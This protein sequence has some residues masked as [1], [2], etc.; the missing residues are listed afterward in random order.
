MLTERNAQSLAKADEAHIMF[1]RIAFKNEG[2]GITK[3]TV[4]G[5]FQGK[6]RTAVARHTDKNEALAIALSAVGVAFDVDLAAP[7]QP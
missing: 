4:R 6:K 7:L 2:N 5:D 1:T 3:C